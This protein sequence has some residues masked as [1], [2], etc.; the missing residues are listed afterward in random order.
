MLNLAM[1]LT[2]PPMSLLDGDRDTRT[3]RQIPKAVA[4]ACH[5]LRKLRKFL[6]R[7]P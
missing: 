4:R 5:R 7:L 6:D 3:T 1:Q 2:A